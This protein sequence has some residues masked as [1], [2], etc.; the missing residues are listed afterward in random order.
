MLR[1]HPGRVNARR[2]RSAMGRYARARR[3]GEAVVRGAG[4]AAGE[5]GLPHRGSGGSA[6]PTPASPAV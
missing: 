6:H 5:L 1:W 3:G 4:A 2:A